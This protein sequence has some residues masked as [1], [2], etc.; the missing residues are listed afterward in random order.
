M[1]GVGPA[2][3]PPGWRSDDR[4]VERERRFDERDGIAD[5]LVG[6][7]VLDQLRRADLVI[8]QEQGALGWLEVG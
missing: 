1:G 5:R 4:H 7:D 2:H 6:V 8:D 3:D